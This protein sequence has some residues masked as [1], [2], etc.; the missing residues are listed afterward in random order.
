MESEVWKDIPGFDFYQISNLG[1]VRSCRFGTGGGVKRKYWR[2]IGAKYD[3]RKSH[4]MVDLLRISKKRERFQLHRLLY[5]V[6]IG[7]IPEGKFIDHIDRNGLNNSLDNLRLADRST[8]VVNQKIREGRKYKGVRPT[9]SGKYEARTS[10]KKKEVFLGRFDTEV[11]AA[12]AYNDY[13]LKQFGEFA[14]LNDIEE[15]H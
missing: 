13:A 10:Y 4:L 2:L 6:F 3:G 8:N 1:R 12:K 15:V 14:V 9:K 5:E 7:P 11:E